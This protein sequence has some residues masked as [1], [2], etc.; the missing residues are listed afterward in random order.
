MILPFSLFVVFPIIEEGMK[1]L[2]NSLIID[3]EFFGSA[4]IIR[5]PELITPKDLD[6]VFYMYPQNN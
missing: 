6:L 1:F 4:K 3:L 5:H 2:S